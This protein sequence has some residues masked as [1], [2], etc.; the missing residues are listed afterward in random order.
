MEGRGG[1]GGDRLQTAC[2]QQM[3]GRQGILVQAEERPDAGPKAVPLQAVKIG[4]RGRHTHNSFSLLE[5][6]GV[7]VRVGTGPWST[8]THKHTLN[9]PSAVHHRQSEGGYRGI[10]TL[11]HQARR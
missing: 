7:C 2:F 8:H 11:V 3:N 9:M 1:R 4:V 10:L 5:T 6:T